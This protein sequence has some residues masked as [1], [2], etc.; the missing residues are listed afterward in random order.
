MLRTVDM[1]AEFG[2]FLMQFTVVGKR[3]HLE[4]TAVGQD[5][6]VPCIELVKSA[7][8]FQYFKTR[9]KIKMIGVTQDNLGVDIFFQLGH[10]D[11]FHCALCSDRHKNGRLDYPVVGCNQARPCICFSIVVL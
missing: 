4:A 7:G 3:E 8:L 6:A 1:R 10:V 9:S 11:S 2:T 5:R